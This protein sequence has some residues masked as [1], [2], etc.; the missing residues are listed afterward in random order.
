M[1]LILYCIFT[2]DKPKKKA[3]ASVSRAVAICLLR[4]HL[5]TQCLWRNSVMNKNGCD[6]L[7]NK[8]MYLYLRWSES[9]GCL[10]IY[11]LVYLFIYL[12]FFYLFVCCCFFYLIFFFFFFL[13]YLFFFLFIFFFFFLFFNFFFFFC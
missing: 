9:F 6:N 2:D 3:P 5:I 4:L 8:Y 13:I 11:L 7:I 10:F 12:F 1:I